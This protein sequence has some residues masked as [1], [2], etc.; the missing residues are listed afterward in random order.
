MG[1][2]IIDALLDL[3]LVS[4]YADFFTLTE[5]DVMD[6]PHFKETA[7]R[8]L[9]SAIKASSRVP[10]E[11][12]LV[13]LS[14]PHVG[15]ETARVIAN[16]FGT[17]ARIR[18]ASQEELEAVYG[19]GE[20]VARSL[21]SYMRDPLHMR[22]LDALLEVVRVVAPERAGTKLAGKTFVF[23][24]TLST[25]SRD[26]AGARARAAGAHVASSV[27]KKTDYVVVGEE[28]G[29]KEE[30]ARSLGVAVLTEEQFLKLL[31]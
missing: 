29:S 17:I 4:S 1:E 2:K 31:S 14:I 5:G 23:T 7:S 24:G 22:E 27:S 15:T 21:A 8:N 30:K 18:K 3:G 20:I 6:L 26:E 9:I 16:H 28:A 11:R 13:A 19:V 25:L 10:L 12:L